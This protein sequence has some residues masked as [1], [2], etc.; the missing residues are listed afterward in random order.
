MDDIRKNMQQRIIELQRIISKA[1]H[2]AERGDD[3]TTQT[4]LIRA[5]YRIT[6]LRRV[7]EHGH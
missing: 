2:A 1:Q 7:N 6:Q 5:S 3:S 4:E